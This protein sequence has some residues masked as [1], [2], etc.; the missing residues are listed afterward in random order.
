MGKAIRRSCPRGHAYWCSTCS[1]LRTRAGHRRSARMAQRP[2]RVERGSLPI[3]I[4][5]LAVGAGCWAPRR[6]SG[7]PPAPPG[8]S[9]RTRA[10]P[11]EP[12]SGLRVGYY[13]ARRRRLVWA[14][15]RLSLVDDSCPCSLSLRRAHRQ[16]TSS[17][18]T[19]E[20]NEVAERRAL[21]NGRNEARA[22][23]YA[24]GTLRLAQ[25]MLGSEMAAPLAALFTRSRR[26]DYATTRSV[27]RTN[28]HL[29]TVDCLASHP[30][31]PAG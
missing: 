17:A 9:P 4:G 13:R 15:P 22:I 16:T 11:C 7:L 24:A 26:H 18:E 21:W 19:P 23:A 12:H 5:K 2:P 3:D 10:N 6:R 30:H 29:L 8:S 20:R 14:H 25:M 28:N 31:P 27:R 1:R